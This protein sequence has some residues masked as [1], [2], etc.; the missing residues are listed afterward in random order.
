MY[1]PSGQQFGLPVSLAQSDA[2]AQTWKMSD[3][4]QVSWKFVGHDARHWVD[5]DFVVQV[6]NV[7]PFTTSVAQ[8]SGALP[9]QSLGLAHASESPVPQD[10]AQ[11]G[12]PESSSK[13]HTL[14][15]PHGTDGQAPA[16]PAPEVEPPELLPLPEPLLPLP[17]LLLP[18]PELLL[19]PEL[20][21]LPEPLPL[22]PELLVLP[23]LLVPELLPL[24]EPPD[25]VFPPSPKSV[26]VLL[27]QPAC[28]TPAST[29]ARAPQTP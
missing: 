21:V 9:L 29:T 22:V 4:W 14:P 19:L 6:G 11:D 8:Q 26:V 7:P 12:A 13:Q 5:R 1:A 20:L 24:V 3:A 23:E 28:R 15:P 16:S 2:V 17:E 18:L 27:P 10:G 25:D